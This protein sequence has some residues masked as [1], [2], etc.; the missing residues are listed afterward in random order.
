MLWLKDL[1]ISKIKMK[2]KKNKIHL[3]MET[4]QQR[5]LILCEW[6]IILFETICVCA[7]YVEI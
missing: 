7:M 6:S 1:N 5:Q 2:R 3:T 4:L